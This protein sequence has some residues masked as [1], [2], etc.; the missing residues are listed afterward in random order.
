MALIESIEG[1]T[2]D[3]TAGV[4]VTGDIRP[5]DP[6]TPAN[7]TL[8]E[9]IASTSEA[10]AGFWVFTAS[11]RTGVLTV[12]T[13]AAGS[14]TRVAS[15]PT[16]YTPVSFQHSAIY[17][18]VPVPAGTRIAVGAGVST[19]GDVAVQL[20]GIPSVNFDAEPDF[21]VM[22]SGPFHLD[23]PDYGEPVVV[24]PGG[25]ANTK[26]S[27]T[28]IS[29]TAGNGPNNVLNGDSLD[30]AYSHFGFVLGDD[31]SN[32]AQTDHDRLWDVGTGASGSEVAFISNYY[33]SFTNEEGSN[34]SHPL[35]FPWDKA[36]GTRVAARMQA[37]IT[38]ATDRLGSIY[39][40]GVR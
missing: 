7:L 37:S 20:A 36:A 40:Y 39:L 8:V 21:T 1:N 27:W 38:D 22:D 33:Q 18:P 3:S 29:K 25:T 10:W 31:F 34:S 16:R 28:E 24:D 35:M 4:V 23:D 15:L 6:F 14:E 32:T 9:A 2:A 11:L 30:H 12:T 26:G 19:T 13:G 5:A 17:V